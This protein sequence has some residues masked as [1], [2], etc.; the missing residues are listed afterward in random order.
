MGTLSLSDISFPSL[1]D[2]SKLSRD[3]SKSSSNGS[4]GPGSSA[5]Q[6]S[7][8]AEA[9]LV[10]EIM[11]EERIYP[12]ALSTDLGFGRGSDPAQVDMKEKFELKG[13]TKEKGCN[14]KLEAI[15]EKTPGWN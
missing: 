7:A 2:N 12:S 15:D 13:C 10:Q 1:P 14:V 11:R 4:K 9:T 3:S 6:M 5:G 8:I